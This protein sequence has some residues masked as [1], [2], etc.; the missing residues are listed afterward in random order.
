M[1]G[2][3]NNP[4]NRS[5]VLRF[6]ASSGR[7]NV[8]SYFCN[9]KHLLWSLLRKL[10]ASSGHFQTGAQ[11]LLTGLNVIPYGFKSKLNGSGYEN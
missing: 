11:N 2:I 7:R 3:N 6:L 10:D 5:M 8:I 4:F 9:D 1:P